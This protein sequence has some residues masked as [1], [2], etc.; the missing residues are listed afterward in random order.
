MLFAALSTLFF[1]STTACTDRLFTSWSGK[2]VRPH[3]CV[4]VLLRTNSNSTEFSYVAKMN[5]ANYKTSFETEI[6]SS[7]VD[8]SLGLK[9]RPFCEGLLAIS[10]PEEPPLTSL[11]EGRGI[12]V[13][14][15]FEEQG[16][17]PHTAKI[18]KIVLSTHVPGLIQKEK[19]KTRASVASLTKHERKTYLSTAARVSVLEMIFSAF[20]QRRAKNCHFNKNEHRFWALDFDSCDFNVYTSINMTNINKSTLACAIDMW[21][22]PDTPFPTCEYFRFMAA[23]LSD[24]PYGTLSDDL[25]M[26]IKRYDVFALYLQPRF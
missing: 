26:R 4:L 20:D 5:H 3:S 11:A 19:L 9:V 18:D 22:V 10:S 13:L 23:S 16:C 17:S 14:S 12:E 15:A 21:E 1:S 8:A 25:Y 2:L 24:V 6:L 7:L